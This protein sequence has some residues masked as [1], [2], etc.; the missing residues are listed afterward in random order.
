[1]L[2]S[3]SGIPYGS[4]VHT[5]PSNT[6]SLKP[7]LFCQQLSLLFK[8]ISQLENFLCC[9][10]LDLSSSGPLYRAI[11]PAW[12]LLEALVHVSPSLVPGSRVPLFCVPFPF[13]PHTS[14]CSR[15]HLP[16][17]GASVYSG[18]IHLLSV[19]PIQLCS[20]GGFS[21]L[22]SSPSKRT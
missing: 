5:S 16:N 4:G 7:Q 2:T 22:L 10:I 12:L 14:P 17:R 6:L 18:Y 13:H 3:L 9:S 15:E 1:M 11:G 8:L 21:A 20:P 19:S